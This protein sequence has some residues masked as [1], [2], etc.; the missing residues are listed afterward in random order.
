[1]SYE[2]VHTRK[3]LKQGF[4]VRHQHG[5]IPTLGMQWTSPRALHSRRHALNACSPAENL[6]I[7]LRDV[8]IHMQ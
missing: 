5:L 7:G 2:Q 3:H 4:F 1:M 6:S 8:V